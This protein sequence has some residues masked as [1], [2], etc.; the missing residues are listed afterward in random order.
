LKSKHCIPVP[1]P[2]HP[3]STGSDVTASSAAH[4]SSS[5]IGSARTF[6]SQESSHSVT[7]GITDSPASPSCRAIQRTVA[8][9]ALPISS[10]D[11][12]TIGDPRM[13]HSR[14]ELIPIS[15]P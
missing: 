9:Y 4:T 8:S 10:D 13:P 15:S 3:S 6:E 1:D 11:V 14:I 5:S 2:T 7:Q 12:R